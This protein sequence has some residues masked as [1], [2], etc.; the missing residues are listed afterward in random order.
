MNRA[1]ILISLIL[2]A[3]AIGAGAA[4]LGLFP[5]PS[6]PSSSAIS[7]I[8]VLQQ[9]PASSVVLLMAP[10]TVG[11]SLQP[12]LVAKHI[13]DELNAFDYQTLGRDGAKNKY[14]HEMLEWYA[15]NGEASFTS[16]LRSL[17]DEITFN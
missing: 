14:R 16:A 1:R 4:P 5:S 15:K 3:L 13:P 17:R 2:S 8:D 10:T 12:P 9:V 7:E 6:D 11:G